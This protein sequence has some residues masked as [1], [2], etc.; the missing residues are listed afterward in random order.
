MRTH[1][2]LASL[3]LL[4]LLAPLAH[5]QSATTPEDHLG[6]PAGTDFQLADW[7]EV[8][9]YFRALAAESDRCRVDV[10]GESTEGREFLRAVFSSRHWLHRHARQ[11]A[12]G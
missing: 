6:R 8:S 1:R 5:P 12:N 2:H 7:S 9:S 11:G 4:A 10:I 3:A